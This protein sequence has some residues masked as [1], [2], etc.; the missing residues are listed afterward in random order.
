[1]F[2]Q[3][4]AVK[5]EVVWVVEHMEFKGLKE[6]LD[7]VKV[8]DDERLLEIFQDGGDDVVRLRSRFVDRFG[9]G[10]WSGSQILREVPYMMVPC[11]GW[12]TGKTGWLHAW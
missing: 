11:C 2:V 1:M 7:L 5:F 10:P 4:R 8:V 12:E 6:V 3:F 9:F